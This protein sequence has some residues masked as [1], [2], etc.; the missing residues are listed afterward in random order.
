MGVFDPM[1]LFSIRK[2]TQL[3]RFINE[4]RKKIRQRTFP[5]KK[6][7]QESLYTGLRSKRV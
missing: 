1:C 3:S 7:I 2:I 5:N 4:N 6:F